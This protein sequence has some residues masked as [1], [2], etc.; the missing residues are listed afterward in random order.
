VKDKKLVGR[1]WIGH[2]GVLQSRWDIVLHPI[3]TWNTETI[4]K[5]MTTCVIIHNMIF[6][7]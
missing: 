4:W 2:F 5:M 1:M 7:D 6:D 3:E